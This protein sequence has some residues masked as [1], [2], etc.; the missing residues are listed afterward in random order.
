[1]LAV[2]EIPDKP[3]PPYTPPTETRTPKPPRMFTPEENL[4]DKVE[5]HITDPEGASC[6]SAEA[7]SVFVRDFCQESL[8][9]HK[10]EQSDMPWDACNLLPQKPPVEIHKLVEKTTAELKDGLTSVTPTAV[11]SKFGSYLFALLRHGEI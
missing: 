5:K 3:P 1:M 2:R 8:E 10:Q 11:S 9:K 6:D 4:Q 7:F